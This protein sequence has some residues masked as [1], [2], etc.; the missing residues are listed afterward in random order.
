MAY[1][2]SEENVP[3]S[4]VLLSQ[5]TGS[6]QDWGIAISAFETVLWFDWTRAYSLPLSWPALRERARVAAGRNLDK[7]ESSLLL[8][9]GQRA[10]FVY[11]MQKARD[12]REH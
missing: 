3:R 2:L 6:Q 5:L 8:P 12:L 10:P 11:T 7:A 9:D 4:G 1:S